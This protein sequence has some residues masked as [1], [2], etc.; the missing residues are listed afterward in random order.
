[1]LTLIFVGP[2]EW[3]LSH[4]FNP[5]QPRRI[6]PYEFLLLIDTPLDMNLN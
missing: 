1:M 2:G 4:V 3:G 6:F 5:I